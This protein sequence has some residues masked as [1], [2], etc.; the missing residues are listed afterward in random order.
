MLS[1]VL[2]DIAL[3]ASLFLIIFVPGVIALGVA[4]LL[5]RRTWGEE[6]A[7]VRHGSPAAHR[8]DVLGQS[9]QQQNKLFRG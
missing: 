5:I 8:F 4:S 7:L 3:A 9:G 2:T 1:F 6:A